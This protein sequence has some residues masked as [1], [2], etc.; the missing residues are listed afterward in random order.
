MPTDSY[1]SASESLAAGADWQRPFG[2]NPPRQDVLYVKYL[3]LILAVSALAIAVLPSNSSFVFGALVG[4]LAGLYMLFDL[5]FRSPPLRISWLLAMSLL[6][7]YGGGAANS[8]LTFPRASLTVSEAFA[9]DPEILARGIAAVMAVCATL[10]FAGQLWERPIFGEDFRLKFDFRSYFMIVLSTALILIAFATGQ[11]GFGGITT[12]KTATLDRVSAFASMVSWWSAPSLA[13][14][15]CATLN[16][17]GVVRTVVGICALIQLVAMIPTGRRVFA[18]ALLLSV[19]AFRLGRFRVK[20]SLFGKLGLLVTS[21][22][23]IFFSAVGF[24]LLR[25]AG[26]ENKQA[27]SLGERLQVAQS[28]IRTRSLSDITQ[29]LQSNV[30]GRTFDIGYF[31]DLLDASEH[32]PPLLGEGMVR[33][34]KLLVPAVISADK[35]GIDPGQEED[36]V[37]K[38][39]GFTYIDEANTILTGGVADFGLVGVFVYPFLIVVLMRA[40]TE[41]TQTTMPTYAAVMIAFSFVYQMLL[42]EA[43]PAS[44]FIQIRNALILAF[45]LYVLPRL[46]K[47]QLGRPDSDGPL[48]QKAAG[49]DR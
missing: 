30:S 17:K 24:Y 12:T 2:S 5:I 35:L 22:V 1:R 36:Q 34:L 46:P 40:V 4:A 25:I 29:L 27:T 49:N 7:A 10:L 15:V 43:Y 28:L 18:F 48:Y 11:I 16:T 3:P 6:L 42:A 8:W 19:I 33:N 45:I 9:R 37:N 38:Q 21:I 23:L 41:W 47:I 26:W 44:Y 14:S 39:W 20:L 31:A 32:S 13:Y